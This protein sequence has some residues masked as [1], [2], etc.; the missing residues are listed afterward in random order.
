M[1]RQWAY[2]D[3]STYLKLII[4]E[5]GS[6]KARKKAR[7]SR[8][9]SSAILSVECFSALSRRKREGGLAESD[10][11]K[12]VKEIKESL[13]SLEIIGVRDDVLKKAEDVTLR[14]TA[15]AMDA[16]HIASA[17]AFQE[18]AGIEPSFVTSDKK[19]SEAA[20][21]VGLRVFFIE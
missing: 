15:R 21:Q 9:L 2:F 17:L 18:G 20:A 3:T 19:Q 16:I 10:F 12:I 11:Q 5:G 13:L 1:T 7:E 8:V 6:E 4:K 14:S